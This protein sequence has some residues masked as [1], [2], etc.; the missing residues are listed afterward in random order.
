MHLSDQEGDQ[1]PLESPPT[2]FSWTRLGPETTVKK[3]ESSPGFSFLCLDSDGRI[4]DTRLG[5]SILGLRRVHGTNFGK[6]KV[7]DDTLDHRRVRAFSVTGEGVLFA[8]ADT[9]VL[10]FHLEGD[11]WQFDGMVNTTLP[12]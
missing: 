1:I 6:I 3:R 12:N 11:E 4:E 10:A 9:E 5:L 2:Q 8:R 7:G